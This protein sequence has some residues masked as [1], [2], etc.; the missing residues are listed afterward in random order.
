[1]EGVGDGGEGMYGWRGKVE[2]SKWGCTIREVACLGTR[3]G[4]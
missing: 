1:M 2:D 4:N 3:E